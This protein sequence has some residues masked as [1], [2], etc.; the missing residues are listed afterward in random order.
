MGWCEKGLAQPQEIRSLIWRVRLHVSG[1]I[2]LG[3]DVDVVHVE[4]LVVLGN[5]LVL[6]QGL[7]VFVLELFDAFEAVA[8]ENGIMT[9]TNDFRG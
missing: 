6:L 5:R 4:I 9:I 2:L 7:L 8:P 1:L 3:F